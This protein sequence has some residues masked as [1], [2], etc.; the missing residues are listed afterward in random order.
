MMM[1]HENAKTHTRYS[2]PI[3]IHFG[4]CFKPESIYGC[5]I[6]QQGGTGMTGLLCWFL[7]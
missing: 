7:Y 4:K 1:L 2:R 6:I 5:P 3:R